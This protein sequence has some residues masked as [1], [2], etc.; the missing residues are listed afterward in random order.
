MNFIKKQECNSLTASM[1]I[2]LGMVVN[3]LAVA[4]TTVFE[5]SGTYSSHALGQFAIA[6]TDSNFSSLVGKTL[7]SPKL[8]DL[9]TQI[10]YTPTGNAN[11]VDTE[12]VAMDMTYQT[13]Q[14]ASYQLCDAAGDKCS[15]L[16]ISGAGTEILAGSSALLGTQPSFGQVVSNSNNG[17]FPANSS[18]DLYVNVY[19]PTILPTG[20]FLY[21]IDPLLL[22]KSN[23]TLYPPQDK[24][25]A[26]SY[27]QTL[28]PATVYLYDASGGYSEVFGVMNVSIVPEPAEWVMLLAGLFLLNWRLHQ[29]KSA[30]ICTA[31]IRKSG[32]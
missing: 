13:N 24:N 4:D 27:L 1:F 19:A 21:N 28:S 12:I 32:C 7:V 3:Q 16:G 23:I 22:S 17:S 6:V 8:L 5:S 29:Q 2:M 31:L 18:F 15:S 9:N 11:V 30:H 26:L 25:T 20:D 10:S 14:A